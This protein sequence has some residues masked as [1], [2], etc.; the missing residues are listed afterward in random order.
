MLISLIVF[1]IIFIVGCILV[2]KGEDTSP[3]DKKRIIVALFGILQFL[4]VIINLL[5]FIFFDCNDSFTIHE[6]EKIRTSITSS[7]E[8]INFQD[9]QQDK[10]QYTY[11]LAYRNGKTES[12]MYYA[13]YVKTEYGY[14][15][16]KIS[17]E[18]KNVYIRYCDENETPRKETE[19]DI[20]KKKEI[21]NYEP[22]IWTTSIFSYIEY[23]IYNKG[24]VIDSYR[25]EECDRT[26]FYIP[27]DSISYQYE[28]DMK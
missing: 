21:L 5:V 25:T 11:L 1:I 12:V 18:E 20:Y 9:T 27:Q 17:P 4:W 28:V 24:D 19:V 14:E 6:E 7:Q 2:I 22:D 16:Q 26:I 15:Y 8:L 10:G 13:Y 3:Q 23:H